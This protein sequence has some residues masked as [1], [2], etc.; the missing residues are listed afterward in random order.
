MHSLTKCHLEALNH[1]LK[2]LKEI[3][4]QRI[5]FVKI[6]NLCIKIYVNAGF[7]FFNVNFNFFKVW[8]FN[9]IDCN[10][11]RNYGAI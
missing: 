10:T 9:A 1:I 5:L 7:S 4:M 11:I 2:Y 6:E 3:P 8:G